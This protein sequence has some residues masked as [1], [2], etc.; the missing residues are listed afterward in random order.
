MLWT[1][2]SVRGAACA[3]LIAASVSAQTPAKVDFARDVL[4]I[5]RQNC[6]GCHGP[7]QQLNGL[8]LDR[9]SSVFKNGLRRVVPG[10]SANSFLI[11]R[12]SGTEYGI[13]M[14][15]TG[16][17]PPAQIET[18]KQWID[19]GAE[20]PDSLANE[21]E[22]PPLNAKA[23]AMVDA[24]GRGDRQAFG[25]FVAD[26]PKLLNARGPDGATPFMYA[27]L[28]ATAET[29]EELLKKGADPNVRNDANATAL[30]FAVTSLEKTRSLLDHGADVNAHSDEMRTPLLIAAGR[31][32]G[33]AVVKLLLDHGAKPDPNRHPLSESSA[34]I[35]AATAGDAEIM[36]LLVAH[37]ADVKAAGQPAISM[38]IF[39][40]C[41]KCLDLLVAGKPD[42]AAYT[43]ALGET[44]VLGDV[45]SVRRLLDEGADVNAAD[46]AGR[47]PLM[48]AAGSDLIPLDEVKLLVERGANVNVKVAH[49]KAVDT[50]WSVLDIARL[51]GNTPIVEFLVKAG[52]KGTAPTAPVLKAKQGNTLPDA[53]ERSLPR[54]Q[55]SDANFVPKAG[56][57]SC[58]NNSLGAM[59]VGLARQRGFHVDEAIASAQV[60]ANVAAIAKMRDRLYQGFFVPVEDNF[61]PGVVAYML[62]GLDAERYR[63]D[64]NTDAA[65]RYLKMHQLPD[66]QW[67]Y[68]DADT[69][70]PLCSDY[71]GQTAMA[72]RALQLYAPAMDKAGYQKSIELAAGWLVGAKSK[73]NDDRSWRLM[74]LVWAGQKDAA[75][76]AMKEL[77]E[78][79]RADGGW[80]D[81]ASMEST[82]YSTGKSLVALGTAGMTA[83]DPA[84]QRGVKFLLS[85][86]QEDGSWYVKTRAL[87]FQPFFDSGFSHGFDQYISAA[88]SNWATMAL[89]LAAPGR[90][91]TASGLE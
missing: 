18:L 46:P 91:V 75:R 37:G 51:R 58:H 35:E 55:Q 4:P 83:S 86:Q 28:Y 65:A 26:D 56:C 87:A 42:K 17:L 53:M 73:V 49:P 88:G 15:P 52:A 24:L 11:H 25:K 39:N 84:Y 50:D 29:V 2:R 19:Q 40:R 44:A 3:S 74:G 85:T 67:A 54:L 13:Q 72:L 8:R 38:A 57:I 79:Q 34:L 68:G 22:L 66:G 7:S 33:R 14:P 6:V 76:T 30:M 1:L 36:Q 61:G 9:K 70:P 78:V 82:A 60:R 90:T 47:T 80:G 59:T 45:T 20:W 81:I 43:G 16:A 27:V 48:Y 12:L 23:V 69:R 89:T 21:A 10:S 5:F 62:M 32:G 41:S 31:P 77:L 63:P 64:L 71:I